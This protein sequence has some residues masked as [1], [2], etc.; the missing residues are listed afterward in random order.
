MRKP[1]PHSRPGLRAVHRRRNLQP[2]SLPLSPSRLLAAGFYVDACAGGSLARG[3]FD[4]DFVD[5][6][7]GGSLAR[8]RFDF[9]DTSEALT[10]MS[11]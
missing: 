6:C 8:G 3:R 4:F 10:S 1:L 2:S 9:D 5:A 11:C 7:A